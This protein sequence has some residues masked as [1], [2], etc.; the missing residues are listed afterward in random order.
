[1]FLLN[2]GVLGGGLQG[3]EAAYLLKKAGHSVIMLDKKPEPPAKGLSDHF[4][5]FDLLKA[6]KRQLNSFN[7]LV[8]AIIPA[9]ENLN[10]LEAMERVAQRYH[11]IFCHDPAAYNTSS[12]KIYSNRFFA[13]LEL[14]RPL[15]WPKAQFPLIIKPSRGSG[16]K[17]VKVVSTARELEEVLASVRNPCCDLIIEEFL[18]GPSYS[19][20]VVAVKG[21]GTAFITTLLHF[22]EQFDCKRV[23]FPSG[24]DKA[25][26][27]LLQSIALKL[28]EELSLTGI[29]DLEVINTAEKLKILEI[30]ARLPSQTPTIVY[31]ASGVNLVT[32]LLNAFLSRKISSTVGME[33]DKKAVIYEHLYCQEGKLFF[34]GEHIL[35]SARDLLLTKDFFGADEAITNYKPFTQN[36]SWVATIIIT[37][38]TEL[39]AWEKRRKMLQEMEKLLNLSL[40]GQKT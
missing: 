13:Q 14:P 25:S 28:A 8:E 30:D 15:P 32:L 23:V 35:T 34:T 40:S 26:Q 4:F 27:F 38:E 2:V 5:C 1:M 20:E 22:D 6:E 17:D 24:L 39:A 16:S 31:H 12:N 29:M 18:E 9:T 10:A 7:Y 19:V 21:K 3:I 11:K 36:N 37:G 33:E